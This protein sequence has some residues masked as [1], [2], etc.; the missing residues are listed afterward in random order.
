M[1]EP[2]APLLQLNVLLPVPPVALTVMLPVFCPAHVM[3]VAVPV[4]LTAEGA[5]IVA[6]AAPVHP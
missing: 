3:F 6:E 5:V 1:V 4:T 2:V